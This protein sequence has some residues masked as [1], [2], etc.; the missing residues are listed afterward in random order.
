MFHYSLD[1]K[2]A[3][4]MIKISKNYVCQCCSDEK[5][6]VE[7]I[8]ENKQIGQ[9]SSPMTIF[10]NNLRIY[11]KNNVNIYNISESC[12][13]FG[14]FCSPCDEIS[15]FIYSGYDNSNPVGE[16]NKRLFPMNDGCCKFSNIYKVNFPSKA[17]I[18]EKLLLISSVLIMSSQLYNQNLTYDNKKIKEKYNDNMNMGD[19]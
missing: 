2:E 19:I 4:S 5:I 7:L 10:D 15:F 3:Q 16:I 14:K 8:S 17:V 18:E 13:Q 6:T 9:I 11:D 1:V 12:C